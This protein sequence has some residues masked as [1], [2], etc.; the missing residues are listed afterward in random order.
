MAVEIDK[1][2]HTDRDSNFEKLRQEALK[3]EFNC[4]FIRVN[5]SKENF[6]VD[7]EASK[8]QLFI[9]QF[10]GNKIKERDT[11]NKKLENEI[12]EKD[13]KNR[14]LEDEIKKL[15]LQLAITIR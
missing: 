10:K 2:S 12:K 14:E 4:N 9:G 11:K 8:I 13:N 3:K 5:T 15:K 7:Y 6:D 1:K